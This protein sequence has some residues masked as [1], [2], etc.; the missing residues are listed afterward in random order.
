MRRNQQQ[1]YKI[2]AKLSFLSNIIQNRGLR[3]INQKI[4]RINDSLVNE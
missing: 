1:N 2:G 3:M 4:V